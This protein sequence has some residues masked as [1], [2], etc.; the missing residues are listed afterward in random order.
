MTR[1][2][3]T[4]WNYS[5]PE[6]LGARYDWLFDALLI[7]GIGMPFDTIIRPDG[8]YPDWFIDELTERW[9]EK[10]DV[11]DCTVEEYA[12]VIREELRFGT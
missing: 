6:E 7:G 8:G 5:T 9:Y 1:N 11:D 2:P 12:E 10:D 4:S 3:P